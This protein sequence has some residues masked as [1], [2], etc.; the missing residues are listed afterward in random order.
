MFEELKE[1]LASGA[2]SQLDIATFQQL[3]QFVINS[4]G[5]IDVAHKN[6]H[7]DSVIALALAVQCLKQVPFPKTLF[8]PAWVRS[9][10][11]SKAVKK[12]TLKSKQRYGV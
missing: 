5:N 4:K 3:K 1:T 6:G 10:K 9:Q 11:Y 2:I 12:L 7:G 8:L